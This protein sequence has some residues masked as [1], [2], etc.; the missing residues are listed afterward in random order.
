MPIPMCSYV[1]HLRVARIIRVFACRR[2]WNAVERQFGAV[3][4][5]CYFLNSGGLLAGSYV[6]TRAASDGAETASA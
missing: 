1:F 2:S 4:R 3:G 5:K 6:K